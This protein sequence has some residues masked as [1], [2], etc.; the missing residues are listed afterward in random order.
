M[1]GE[2]KTG[3][4]FVVWRA[5]FQFVAPVPGEAEEGPDAGGGW[6][7]QQEEVLFCHKCSSEITSPR[8]DGKQLQRSAD[9]LKSFLVFPSPCPPQ[10]PF[11][12]AVL[13]SALLLE[14]SLWRTQAEQSR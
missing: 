8:S 14:G 5:G 11:L 12:R 10:K 6:G 9:F 4:R 7:E 13:P 1:C 2:N 3:L